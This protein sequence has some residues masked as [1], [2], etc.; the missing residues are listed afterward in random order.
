MIL[1][2]REVKG[3]AAKMMRIRRK[4]KTNFKRI[5][6][7]FLALVLIASTLPSAFVSAADGDVTGNSAFRV[8][9]YNT[10]ARI[11]MPYIDG[12]TNYKVYMSE[13]SGLSTFESAA[14]VLNT[15]TFKA[16]SYAVSGVDGINILSNTT[17]YFYFVTNNGSTDTIQSTFEAKTWSAAKYWTD[18]GNYDISWYGDGS[19]AAFTLTTAKQL[20]GLSVLVNGLNGQS[21]VDFAGKTINLASSVDLSAYLWTSIGSV[22]YPFAG[23]FDG[24]NYTGSTYNNS[25]LIKALHTN[26]VDLDNQGL[27]GGATGNISNIGVVDSSVTGL[28]KVGGVVGTMISGSLSNCYNTGSVSGSYA[29]VGGIAGEIRTNAKAINCYN[30]GAVSGSAVFLGGVSGYN[31]GKIFNCYNT[32]SVTGAVSD[33]GGITGDNT[34]IISNSYNTGSVTATGEGSYFVAGIA[35]YNNGTIFNSYNMGTISATSGNNSD[36][37]GVI[38]KNDGSVSNCYNTG[39]VS[40]IN[41]IGGVVA[42]GAMGTVA[43]CYNTGAISGTLN[44]GSIV[45]RLLDTTVTNCAYLTGTS[46]FGIGSPSDT[47]GVSA[48]AG[49]ILAKVNTTN[50]WVAAPT[51][52]ASGVFSDSNKVNL[53]YP[54]LKS[55][56]YRAAGYDY[57]SSVTIDPVTGVVTIG[58]KGAGTL[59]DPFLISNAYHLDLARGNPSSYFKIINNIDISPSQYNLLQDASGSWKPI[60]TTS[61]P[62]KAVNGAG[63]S[64]SGIY[65]N[66]SSG[67]YQG[68]FGVTSGDVKNLGISSGTVLGYFETGGIVGRT[69]G[70]TVTNCYNAA[71]IIAVGASSQSTAGIVG[72]NLSGVVT[73]CFNAGAVMATGASSRQIAGV[74]GSKN[75]TLT[76]S[77]NIGAITAT[78]SGSSYVGGV[79]GYIGTSTSTVARCHNSGTVIA[80]G[81]SSSY[82][83]GIGNGYVSDSY[84]TGNVS[85]NTYVGGITNYNSNVPNCYNTGTISG[86]TQVG[87]IVGSGVGASNCYNTGTIVGKLNGAGGIMGSGTASYSYNTGKIIGTQNSGGLSGIGNAF[88]SYNSGTVTGT[89]NSTGGLVGVGTATNSYNNGSV[90]GTT[91]V[92]G[93][94]GTATSNLSNSYNTGIVIGTSNIG[95]V[96]GSKSAV[97]IIITNSYFAGYPIGV[98]GT[99][100]AQTGTTAFAALA[101]SSIKAGGAT[102]ISEQTTAA[103]NSAWSN[104]LGTDFSV[105]YASPYTSSN[106]GVATV[107]GININSLQI[108]TTNINGTLTINQN[109][110]TATGFNAAAQQSIVPLSMPLTVTQTT[111]TITVDAIASPSIGDS[112]TITATIADGYLP[113]GTV[114]FKNNGTAIGSPVTIAEIDH[115][116]ASI[117]CTIDSMTALSI[118]A[119]YSGDSNNAAAT[120]TPAVTA[121]VSKAHPVISLS[122]SPVSPG[123]FPED[124]VLTAT[125]TDAYPSVENQT[126]TFTINGSDYT[127]ATNA[128][129]VATYTITQPAVDTYSIQASYAGDANN[130]TAADSLSYDVNKGTQTSISVSGIA[131]EVIY[132]H[133][134]YTLTP[135]GGSGTGDF[136][137]AAQENKEDVLT[138]DPATGKITITGVGTAYVTVTKAADDNYNVISENVNITVTPKTLNAT[139]TVNDKIYDQTAAATADSISYDGI[140]GSDAVSIA[141]GTLSFSD[142]T[143]ADDKSVSASGYTLSGAKSANYILGTITVNHANI[144]KIALSITNTQVSDK[145][146]DGTTSASFVAAPAL[147]GVLTNDAVAL[148]L[149]TPTFADP[150]YYASPKTVTFTAFSIS[151]ADAG[152]YTVIQPD[153]VTASISQRTLSVSVSP[154]SILCGQAIPTLSVVID[155]SGFAAG[156]DATLS[157]FIIPTAS[158]AYGS[159]LTPVTNATLAVTY[160]SGDATNN[161]QFSYDYDTTLTIQAVYIQTGDYQVSGAYS[162][163]QNPADW[164]SSDLTITP[165]NGYNLISADGVSWGPSITLSSEALNGSVTFKLRKED[166]SHPENMFFVDA[167]AVQTESTTIYYN[168]DNTNPTGTITI[169][170]N[171]FAGF[172]NTI[173]FGKFYKDIINV[174]IVGADA[175]SGIDTIEYQKLASESAYNVNGTWSAYT[176]SFNVSPNE[177]FVIYAKITDHAGNITI[178]NSNGF[179]AYTDSSLITTTAHFDSVTT[180]PGY[181]DVPVTVNFNYNSLKEIKHNSDTLVLNT[182]YTVSGNIITLKK[183]Y[184][185]TVFDGNLQLTFRFNPAG[186]SFVEGDAPADAVLTIVDVV[187]AVAP[188]YTT[189]LS[190]QKTYPKNATATA[191]SVNATVTDGG[192]VTYQWY[193]NNT[194]AASGHAISGATAATYTP[195]TNTIGVLYYYVI[196]TNTNTAASGTQTASATSGIYQIT[197]KNIEVLSSQV[198]NDTPPTKLNEDATKVMESVLTETDQQK[199]DDG[200]T[201]SVY[202][203]IEETEAAK[204]DQKLI[205]SELDGNIMGLYLDISLIKNVDGVES[206]IVQTSA[207]LR[208]TIDIPVELRDPDRA[209]VV[210]RVHDGVAETLQDLDNDP[211]TITIETDRFSTYALAY[212]AS[213][214][215][216]DASPNTGDHSSVIP[217]ALLGLCSLAGAVTLMILKKKTIKK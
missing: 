98:G 73:Y 111:P 60:G 31:E 202:L 52:Y 38:G 208:I 117:N 113:T 158:Q 57:S 86:S 45:G 204:T 51:S 4:L 20:A 118:T 176:G 173:T 192:A 153:P 34:G 188:S 2:L 56:G 78:G 209:F 144:E 23:T 71:T 137:F 18:N 35:S 189:N 123:T 135:S 21:A 160:D 65:I 183:E 25:N 54:V 69:T 61:V 151:G 143:A 8:I 63:F 104:A 130:D 138:L 133:S 90:T 14:C 40:G 178:I 205:D 147:S 129:G 41:S 187:N 85:G 150:N 121:T 55:Y 36:I 159:T 126:I 87:G 59:E 24:G 124:I 182:D 149:G 42:L 179:I 82:I 28:W 128:S 172:I 201:I 217:I 26:D 184:L 200:S 19:A 155:P 75:A 145:E 91:N 170:E 112:I 203:K 186:V 49:E 161:Y 171:A 53:G 177:K 136:S 139:I 88:C 13:T 50:A 114:T 132:S 196:A 77:Y 46:A 9:P 101:N 92:G 167:N 62:F 5:A 213:V 89:A 7:G 193:V 154:V 76:D 44:A 22:V 212:S 94:A 70:G 67:Y 37:G 12:A 122:A 148:T 190:G 105:S 83:G 29:Q 131:D 174:S 211:N 199:L 43:N 39:A 206:N 119:E 195:P 72:Y 106:T 103:I 1:R 134:V 99:G 146:Y 210:I 180:N 84:N 214:G 58:A 27:F 194:N 142:E 33:I 16:S 95:G 162:A 141:G 96:A 3:L 81:A 125:L 15:A 32:G 48:N 6:I 140:V 110:L 74:V 157:G 156:E 97:N 164:N 152:N 169:H 166:M 107:S 64:I 207:P 215:S 109:G 93:V 197:V 185:A 120:S 165:S 168:L 79:V 191:L 30:T 66:N 115:G 198:A 17:Y 127:A 10:S 216:A 175:A 100:A 102:T 108:G 116:V 68:L 11:E 181:K 80:T 163:S 47:S